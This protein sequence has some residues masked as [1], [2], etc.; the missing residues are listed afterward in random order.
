MTKG[1]R[2]PR[3]CKIESVYLCLPYT[4]PG[5][6]ALLSQLSIFN[7]KRRNEQ[8]HQFLTSPDLNAGSHVAAAVPE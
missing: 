3:L 8:P 1:I 6:A 4:T 2:T 5:Y 7:R